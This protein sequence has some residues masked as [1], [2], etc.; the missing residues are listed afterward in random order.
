MSRKSFADLG[1]SNAVVKSLRE[2]GIEKPFPVQQQVIEDIL[3]GDDVLVQSP[4]GSGKTLAFGVPLADL[5][6]A[7]SRRPAALILAP[8]RE[9]AS[10]IVD[11]MEGICRARAL[12]IAAVYGGVGM[13]QQARRAARAHIIVACPGRLEDQ[14]QRGAFTLENVKYLVLDEADRML[15]MGF[16]P[17]VDR[18]VRQIDGGRQTLFFSATLEGAA[19]KLAASYTIDP[20]THL[21]EPS[22]ENRGR[23]EHRFIHVSHEAKV[24]TLVNELEQPGRGRTLVFVRTKHGAD[25]LVKKLGKRTGQVRAAAMHGNKSQNQ[26]QRALADFED[27]KVDTL[28]ATDV[29]ARGIDVAEVTHVINFDMPED[30]DTFVHRVG[31]TGR[32]GADGIGVSF[33]MA[34]QRKEMGRIATSLGLHAEWEASGGHISMHSESQRTPKSGKKRAEPGNENGRSR[35]RAGQ[36]GRS[37]KRRSNQGNRNRNR[38]QRRRQNP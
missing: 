36:Q 35:P 16:K 25:R 8:T 7:D 30:Q 31:R 32:A 19:G 23:I 34:D 24:E 33:V 5:V 20:K 17:A 27:G 11:E 4:T 3:D 29:A 37:G 10:Q 6:A 15:D 21:N 12:S 18:I 2:R 9:L 22:L 28:V 26:R 38:N 14:L 13:Q 1:V